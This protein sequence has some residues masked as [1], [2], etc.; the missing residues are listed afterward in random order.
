MKELRKAFF[1][2]MELVY[3]FHAIPDHQL[4]DVVRIFIMGWCESLREHED[5][6]A[7]EKVAPLMLEVA[8]SRWIP[9]DS[10]RWWLNTN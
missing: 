2:C 8:D 3:G 9:D 5:F 6:P 4:S 1:E 7:I 10:W